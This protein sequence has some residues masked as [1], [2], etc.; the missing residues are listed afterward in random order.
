MSPYRAIK[1]H[2][3]RFELSQCIA[4]SGFAKTSYIQALPV[5]LR[6]PE[7]VGLSGLIFKLEHH[8]K[9]GANV[10][11]CW[12]C[13]HMPR[14]HGF[15]RSQDTH[16]RLKGQGTPTWPKDH[17]SLRKRVG[18]SYQLS[19]LQVSCGDARNVLNLTFAGSLNGLDD[20]GTS[21]RFRS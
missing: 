18:L 6:S 1:W 21:T 9:D 8:D 7:K 19:L 14:A 10:E 16:H 13:S 12:G 4:L 15:A 20:I 11:K 2:R 5:N 17:S 3:M